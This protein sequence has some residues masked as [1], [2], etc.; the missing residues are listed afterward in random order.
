MREFGVSYSKDSCSFSVYAPVID[1]ITLAL[2]QSANA[3]QRKLY[4]MNKDQEGVFNLTIEG[5]LDGYFYTYLV[6]GNEITDPYSVAVSLNGIR[7]AIVDL[8]TTNP[9]GFLEQKSVTHKKTASVIYEL[10]VKDFTFSKTSHAK[11]RGKYLGVVEGGL[12]N[13]GLSVGIDHLKDLGITHVHLMPVFDF[14]TVNENPAFFEDEDNYNWGYDPLHYNVPEG[15]Y[16]TDPSN[17]KNRIYELKTLIMEL[18]KANIGVILDVVYNH[19]FF[20]ES[21]NFNVL[22]PDYYYRK[23]ANNNFS[24]GSGCGSE[25]ASEK[26][27]VR[28]FIVDSLVYWALEYKVD[29]FRFDLIAL[30]D[31]DTVYTIV[32]TLKEVNPNI[33]IYGEPWTAAPSSLR[34]EK[35]TLKGTQANQDFALFNDIFRDAIKG[36]N[37]GY[38]KGFAQSNVYGKDDVLLGLIGSLYGHYNG[39][40]TENASESINYVNSHDNLI[41]QDKLIRLYPHFS[42][43]EYI[44]LNKFIFAIMFFAQGIPFMHAGNEFMRSKQLDHNSYNSGNSLNA[45]NW[46]LKDENLELYDYIK[47]LIILKR[48]YPEFQLDTRE[49]IEAKIKVLE[50]SSDETFIVYTIE[51]KK[52]DKYLLIILNGKLEEKILFT[53]N[54]KRHLRNAY[55]FDFDDIELDKM[56]GMNGFILEEVDRWDPYGVITRS[57]SAAIWE[58]KIV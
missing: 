17:P 45:I 14:V 10:H 37:D 39:G 26:A 5:D 24:D 57:Q 32:E 2:Y 16:A 53:E 48:N 47:E 19:T 25:I 9:P 43:A 11:H 13:N 30:M 51:S 1:E 3:I 22:Y 58:V 6:N 29:G 18:H 8:A 35:L 44:K 52:H 28:K 12:F 56:F 31:R 42:A 15:S 38:Y 36:D 27:M 41:L 49:E 55:A 4:K 54:I 21:S 46:D 33:L 34:Y 50:T 7:S 40:F 20:S 23:D